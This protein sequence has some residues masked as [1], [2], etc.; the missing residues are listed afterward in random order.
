MTEK[1]K[2]GILISGRGSNMKALINAAKAPDYPAEI[3]LV[4]SN[5]PKAKGLELAKDSNIKTKTIS[6]KDYQTREEFDQKVTHALEEAGVELLCNAG[7]MRLHSQQF[8]ETWYNRQ[9]NIHPSLLPALKGLNSHQRALDG[10][11]KITGC[12]VHFVRFEM[13]TGPIIAQAAVE[14][15]PEDTVETLS[16]RVLQAEHQLYPEA[17]RQVASGK[18]KIVGERL[19]QTGNGIQQA[20]LFSPPLTK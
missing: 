18:A 10:N 19:I 7:F 20:P 9:L 11:L 5:N 8:V 16:D 14:I 15:R 6:H 3:V 1:R 13:D 17:L 2:V 12:T 4:I